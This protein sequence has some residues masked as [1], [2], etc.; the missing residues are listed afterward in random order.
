M[1]IHI[2]ISISISISL[3]LSLSIYLYI[4]IYIYT[5]VYILSSLTPV[6]D[7]FLFRAHLFAVIIHTIENPGSRNWGD[8]RASA[9]F[10]S[11]ANNIYIYIYIYIYTCL[12][13]I[14]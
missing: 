7:I 2:S 5:Y 6:G 1:Y 14:I 9:G 4:Y 12:Y 13:K 10:L 8:F 11:L 3:S